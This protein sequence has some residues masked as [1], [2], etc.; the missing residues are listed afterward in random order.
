MN[1]FSIFIVEDDK[2]YGEYLKHFISSNP[3]YDTRLFLTGK[4]FIDNIHL[5]PD[6]VTLD[7]NLPDL[8]GALVLKKIRQISPETQV[9]IVSGQKD[10]STALGLLKDGAYDY[11]VK[12]QDSRSRLWNAILRIRENR[13]LKKQVEKLQEEV[14]RKYDFEKTIVGNSQEVRNIYSL[15]E[16]ASKTNINVSITG[17]TGTG[18]EVVAKAIHYNSIR[19]KK[20]FVAVNMSAIPKDLLESELFGY[21]KGA[22]TGANTRKTGKFEEASEGT[23]FLDE[24]GD[25]D[26]ALQSKLLRVIQ[27]RELVRIGGKDT[28]SLDLRLIVATHR[29]LKDEVAKG[30]FRQDLFYRLLGLP[31][32]LPPLRERTNDILILAKHFAESFCKENNL[33]PVGF[34]SE[35]SEKLLRYSY[36]GNIRELKAI[37]DLSVVM[38][39][40]KT[41]TPEDIIFSQ[42]TLPTDFLNS[43]EMT[44]E[45]Y[46]RII[47]KSY[48]D[49]YKDDIVLVSKKLGIG[50]ST[51]YRMKQNNLI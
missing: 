43:G 3:D 7:Y 41:L 51:L 29:D 9:I 27:E 39:N 33:I 5:K 32:H 24:I 13:A 22:F 11:I 16:K 46:T 4:E 47:I 44:M 50:K 8:N 26:I 10:I 6:V 17:E 48:L 18:K 38:S 49:K 28:I 40:G 37:I 21:E 30:N 25:M 36:P 14:A 1:S 35:A 23:L 19:R 12:D 34:S 20:P 15:I 31:I 45:E 2:F 42:T